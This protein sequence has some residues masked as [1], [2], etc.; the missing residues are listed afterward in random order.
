MLA[1]GC[2]PKSTGQV[3]I[4]ELYEADLCN[5]FLERKVDGFLTLP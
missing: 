4:M 2:S 3:S 5:G 1:R